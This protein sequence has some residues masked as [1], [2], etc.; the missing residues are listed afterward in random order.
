MRAMAKVD[1]NIR[2]RLLAW[3]QYLLDEYNLSVPE[4]AK[5]MGISSPGLYMILNQRRTPGL[6]FVIK[7]HR[8][9]GRSMDVFV[10]QDPPVSRSRTTSR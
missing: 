2:Q 4:M 8:A 10:D 7:L 3:V 9:F 1:E 5:R 6:D